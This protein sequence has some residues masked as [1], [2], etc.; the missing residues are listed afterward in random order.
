MSLTISTSE[1]RAHL[2]PESVFIF[3]TETLYG[4][5]CS[6][7]SEDAIARVFNI[8]NRG[9]NQPPP[10]LIADS[11]HLYELVA[12]APPL[13]RELITRFW[14]GALTLVLPARDEVP[15][16]LCGLSDDGVTKTIGVR[17]T[18][19]PVAAALCNLLGA[20]IIATSA[21]FSGAVG[22][23]AAPRSLEEIPLELK[24]LVD[25]V[26]RGE[27]VGG[28]P[29]TVVDCVSAP[30]RILRAGACPVELP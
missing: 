8:K 21:N 29:S 14:P 28:L 3:P 24:Q 30:P 1:L 19:H 13:A 17:Q 15:K 11:R 26:I 20:P 5:G 7:Y 12:E 9:Q 25:F 23:A 2:Q 22:T 16:V 27:A 4:I 18:A 10:V 6:I